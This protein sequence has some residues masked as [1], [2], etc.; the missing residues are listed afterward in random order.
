MPILKDYDPPSGSITTTTQ[1]RRQAF[2]EILGNTC[3]IG[4]SS[5][6]I[7]NV[8]PSFTASITSSI[9]SLNICGTESVTFT[10]FPGYATATYT[11]YLNGTTNIL[12]GPSNTRTYTGSFLDGDNVRVKIEYNSCEIFSNPWHLMLMQI[13][14]LPYL[15]QQYQEIQYASMTY[16]R[17]RHKW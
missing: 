17:L 7:I 4:V 9:P 12:Q 11:F 1:F 6:T 2:V 3:E 13:Q 15:H 8:D 16:L 10:A 14:L 5:V